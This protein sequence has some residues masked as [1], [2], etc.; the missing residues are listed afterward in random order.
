MSRTT[1]EFIS[2]Q[3]IEADHLA[4][5]H[6]EGSFMARAWQLRK[7]SLEDELKAAPAGLPSPRTVLFFAG[8]DS[9]L[10]S[11]GIDA[12]LV[13]D[14]IKPFQEMV[15]SEFSTLRHG[16]VGRRG[17]RKNEDEARLFLTALP[18]GS[19]GLELS[20]PNVE[21]WV[22]AQQLSTTLARLTQIVESAGKSDEDF[23]N[24]LDH[25][26]PRVLPRLRDFLE[27]A[28]KSGA[29]L[30]IESGDLRCELSAER[31]LQAKT[32]ATTT[33]TETK[34]VNCSGIFR[35]ATLDTWRFDFKTDDD[36]SIS[37]ELGEQLTE[38][39]V[40]EMNLLTNSPCEAT[41]NRTAITPPSGPARTKFELVDLRD[42]SRA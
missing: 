28:S 22:Q 21:D 14:I 38:E 9:V 15:K 26:S 3:V 17:P 39:Q 36:I 32:R 6:G 23:A 40:A 37:G 10:G 31:L 20:Q 42:K 8:G 1:R 4:K 27:V 19:F 30:R 35:G 18:R 24:A 13:A 2:R 5:L 25:V 33:H 34:Q 29:S 12:S 11:Q 7:A 16:T 41:L